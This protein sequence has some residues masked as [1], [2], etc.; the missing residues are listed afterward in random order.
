MKPAEVLK[1]LQAQADELRTYYLRT[2][3]QVLD[4]KK[5]FDRTGSKEASDDYEYFKKLS[6]DF[7]KELTETQNTYRITKKL[8]KDHKLI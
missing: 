3:K 6:E 5:E 7:K 4:S 1:F 8:Y 2:S